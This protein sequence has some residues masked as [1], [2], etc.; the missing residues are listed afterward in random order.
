LFRTSFEAGARHYRYERDF[1]FNKEGEDFIMLEEARR[2]RSE[3]QALATWSKQ[4]SDSVEIEP[5]APRVEF[6]AIA[7]FID[8]ALR[9]L[10]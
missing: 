4:A 6:E 1:L 2:S 7:D 9:E 5:E 8:K 3:R 10:G